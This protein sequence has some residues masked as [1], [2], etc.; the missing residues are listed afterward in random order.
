MKVSKLQELLSQ[1]DQN[2]EVVIF[3]H[4]EG[5]DPVAKLSI[6]AVLHGLCAVPA[7]GGFR[8]QRMNRAMPAKHGGLDLLVGYHGDCSVSAFL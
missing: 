1:Q 4:E 5:Y 3:G 6:Q 2:M 8:R 7:P